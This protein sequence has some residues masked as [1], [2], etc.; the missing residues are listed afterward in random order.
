MKFWEHRFYITLPMTVFFFFQETCVYPK[1]TVSTCI[2]NWITDRLW[3][4]KRIADFIILVI[5]LNLN[6]C[7]KFE[8]WPHKS[9]SL[10]NEW[11]LFIK[12]STTSDNFAKNVKTGLIVL[13]RLVGTRNNW[14]SWLSSM[15][16][17]SSLK[18]N[19][20]LDF[21]LQNPFYFLDLFFPLSVLA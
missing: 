14:R 5:W 18:I 17:Y 3:L 16:S 13:V 2:E 21:I 6:N 1:I 10:V 9:S 12:F 19:L 15:E 8:K 20:F 4:I 7:N 11:K